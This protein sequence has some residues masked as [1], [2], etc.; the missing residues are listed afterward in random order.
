MPQPSGDGLWPSGLSGFCITLLW[1]YTTGF[2]LLPRFTLL[3]QNRKSLTL[4]FLFST[5][6]W[7]ECMWSLSTLSCSSW[8][9]GE[10]WSSPLENAIEFIRVSPTLLYTWQTTWTWI[11]PDVQYSF[12]LGS[13]L[14]VDSTQPQVCI[15]RQ[16]TDRDIV[17]GVASSS[18]SQPWHHWWLHRLVAWLQLPC[19]HTC[20]CKKRMQPNSTASSSFSLYSQFSSVL[21]R[22]LDV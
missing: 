16:M 5:P 12:F 21:F 7:V 15:F 9:G 4:F 11:R 18:M 14:L 3:C 1:A 22:D 2:L 6:M 8:A 13:E 20:T 19:G 10:W 17:F